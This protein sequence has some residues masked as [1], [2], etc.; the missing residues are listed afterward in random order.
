MLFED[1]YDSVLRRYR[2]Y[3]AKVEPERQVSRGR[4][5]ERVDAA[6]QA[7]EVQT[8]AV[9]EEKVKGKNSPE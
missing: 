6:Q 5:Y 4:L 3:L 8:K 2:A 9:Q 7:R 1:L